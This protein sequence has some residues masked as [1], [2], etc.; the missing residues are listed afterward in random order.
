MVPVIPEFRSR[1]SQ[2][3]LLLYVNS[4][5][6]SAGREA[7]E[8][9]EILERQFHKGTLVLT[10]LGGREIGEP[11]PCLFTSFGLFRGLEQIKYLVN[12]ERVL[13]SQ[14]AMA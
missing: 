6:D 13:H 8:L 11:V 1:A 12:T 10:E 9:V 3:D 5:E 14:S 4:K 7:V 2:T